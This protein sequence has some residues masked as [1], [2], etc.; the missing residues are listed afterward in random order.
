MHSQGRNRR[1]E[2]TPLLVGTAPPMKIDPRLAAYG[3]VAPAIA[4][5]IIVWFALAPT[6]VGGRAAY[7]LVAGN[8]MEPLLYRDDMVVL[9]Q[10]HDY[11]VGDVVTY[12]NPDVGPVIHRIVAQEGE[13]FIL[14]GDNNTWTDSYK[15]RASEILGEM[16]FHLPRAGRVARG[17][18]TPWGAA[19]LAGI[20]GAF[21]LWPDLWPDDKPPAPPTRQQQSDPKLERALSECSAALGGASLVLSSKDTLLARAGPISRSTAVAIAWRVERLW[22]ADATRPVRAW[23]R[24][25]YRPFDEQQGGPC[26]EGD[27]RCLR[28]YFVTVENNV[29]LLVVWDGQVSKEALRAGAIQAARSLRKML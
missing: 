21:V 17:F 1:T 18:R 25:G 4:L 12:E 11:Q 10:T 20:V 9:R 14:Q 26:A 24:I 19:I 7:V 8:S 15:P 23:L 28:L 13:Q 29:R 5:L 16:W 6:Q 2:A 27:G 3:K 22:Q